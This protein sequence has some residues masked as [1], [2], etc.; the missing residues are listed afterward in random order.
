MKYDHRTLT[1]LQELSLCLA[2]Y[3]MG[4][5]LI[6]DKHRDGKLHAQSEIVERITRQDKKLGESLIRKRV[7]ELKRLGLLEPTRGST[8]ITDK[9]KRTL[10]MLDEIPVLLEKHKLL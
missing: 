5:Y 10:D 9:G 6:L 1:K 3:D 4:Y 8:R 2:L 7:R